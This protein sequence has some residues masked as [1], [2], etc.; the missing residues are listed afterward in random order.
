[1][2]TY[3]HYFSIAINAF[4]TNYPKGYYN[5]FGNVRNKNLPIPKGILQLRTSSINYL[6]PHFNPTAQSGSSFFVLPSHI[7]FGKRYFT[8]SSKLPFNCNERL[9]RNVFN[10]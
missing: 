3:S 7:A 9:N 10:G 5:H 1:M 2:R 8:F 4:P 6:R